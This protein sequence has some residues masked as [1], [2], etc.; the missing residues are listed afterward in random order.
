MLDK[1][2]HRGM[3][4]GLRESVIDRVYRKIHAAPGGTGDA[5]HSDRVVYSAMVAEAERRLGDLTYGRPGFRLRSRAGGQTVVACPE[6]VDVV[7]DDR[8]V[9]ISASGEVTVT[10]CGLSTQVGAR[11]V[12]WTP[13]R[14]ADGMAAR[15]YLHAR[16]DDALDSW[17]R[18]VRD[19]HSSGIAFAAK[20]GGSAAMLDRADC[21]VLYCSA[22]D[23]AQVA[24]AAAANCP[25]PVESVPGFSIAQYPGVGVALAPEADAGTM[26]M[27]V[28]YYWARALVK[29]WDARGAEGLE[30]VLS[31]LAGSWERA[32]RQLRVAETA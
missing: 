19:L 24:S 2:A 9:Y 13:P 26:A 21:V 28:G 17:C 20:V 29:A 4:A 3:S 23:L 32:R 1:H 5:L 11:W 18:I 14:Q 22:E 16:P 7:V 27:S 25:D 12:Y 10:A 30:P 8:Q 15:V 6:G 31:R